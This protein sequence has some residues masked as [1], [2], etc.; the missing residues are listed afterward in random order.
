[1]R[2]RPL[3]C[4]QGDVNRVGVSAKIITGLKQGDFGP[5]AM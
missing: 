2:Y 1:M 5:G 4:G 3:R